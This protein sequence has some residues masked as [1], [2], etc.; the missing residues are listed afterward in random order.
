MNIFQKMTNNAMGVG[1]ETEHGVPEKGIPRCIHRIGNHYGR[2]LVVNYLC[3]ALSLLIITIPAAM[4]GM[5]SYMIKLYRDGFGMEYKHVWK[6]F[7]SSFGKSL[8]IGIPFLVLFFYGMYLQGISV[9]PALEQGASEYMAIIGLVL[10]VLALAFMDNCLI[11]NA[12][13]ELPVSLLIKNTALVMVAVPAVFVGSLA[14]ELLFYLA[15]IRL[16]LYML[17]L[18]LLGLWTIKCL[19]Q[20][21]I[22]YPSIQ[23]FVIRESQTSESDE[24]TLEETESEE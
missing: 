24:E 1:N 22:I 11:M 18:F 2:I 16:T 15:V 19:F 6:E 14:V 12:A 4:S 17:P 20:V 21:G 23:K 3:I 9:N 13:V 8:L 7:R 5:Y 10:T